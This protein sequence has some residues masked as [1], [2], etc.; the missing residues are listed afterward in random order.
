[1]WD[2]VQKTAKNCWNVYS[3]KWKIKVYT[4]YDTCYILPKLW[5]FKRKI[6]KNVK[7]FFLNNTIICN[8]QTLKLARNLVFIAFLNLVIQER[9]FETS[10][11][12]CYFIYGLINYNL[13]W[14]YFFQNHC[15]Q[16]Y[17]CYFVYFRNRQ[18]GA[19]GK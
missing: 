14:N 18:G 6:C 10:A 7:F 17:A 11:I 8:S 16:L 13:G 3:K 9:K 1:M 15:I 19:D 2:W 4:N 12:W 5:V